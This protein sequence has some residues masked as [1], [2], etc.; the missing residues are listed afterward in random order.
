MTI[1]VPSDA[2]RKAFFEVEYNGRRYRAAE[3]FRA[4]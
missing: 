2:P 1:T 3:P 4:H